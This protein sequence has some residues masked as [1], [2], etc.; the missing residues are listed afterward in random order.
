VPVLLPKV[1]VPPEVSA[2][3]VPWLMMLP[4]AELLTIV[5]A[6]P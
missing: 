4:F 6:W 5:P 1:S 2:L 3:I